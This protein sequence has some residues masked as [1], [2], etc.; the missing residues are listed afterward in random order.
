MLRWSI[1]EVALNSQS[2]WHRT[3]IKMAQNCKGR[4]WWLRLRLCTWPDRIH[5]RSRRFIKVRGDTYG[6][7]SVR[8]QRRNH[9]KIER[10]LAGHI[11]K[12]VYPKINKYITVSPLEADPDE[13]H[14]LENPTTATPTSARVLPIIILGWILIF[15]KVIENIKVVTI[16]PPRI[17]W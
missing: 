6:V 3:R 13:N 4:N 2:C 15:K 1:G 12:F 11:L 8:R 9:W 16:V 5:P 17:I 14:K 7:I 10:W